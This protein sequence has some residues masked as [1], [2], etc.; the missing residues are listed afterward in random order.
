MDRFSAVCHH[1]RVFRA[2]GDGRPAE[3]LSARPIPLTL[4]EPGRGGRPSRPDLPLGAILAPSGGA[5]IGRTLATLATLCGGGPPKAE[6]RRG[7]EGRGELPRRSKPPCG[8]RRCAFQPWTSDSPIGCKTRLSASSVSVA[9]ASASSERGCLLV[10]P[11]SFAQPACLL[12]FFLPRSPSCLDVPSMGFSWIDATAEPQ[13]A[14]VARKGWFGRRKPQELPPMAEQNV[15]RNEFFEVHF[16]PHT[17]RDP[18]DLGLLQS[19]PA[20]GPANR[21]AAAPRRRSRTPTA[22]YTI[23]AADELSVTSA[24][25]CWAKSSVAAG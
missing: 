17:G 4:L 22:N 19:Q 21:P 11:G 10:N 20:T 25:P 7:K 3:P 9:K 23:M 5:A 14:T 8:R 12:H 13:A 2:N 16:D 24:G 18:C 1:H 15:L 6:G